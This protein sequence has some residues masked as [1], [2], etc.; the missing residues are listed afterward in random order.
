MRK[1]I[2]ARAKLI[3]KHHVGDVVR[4]GRRRVAGEA[5]FD[6]STL[7]DV[8]KGGAGRAILPLTLTLNLR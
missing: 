6:V 3:V 1:F 8:R 2:P 4:V 7:A 5:G